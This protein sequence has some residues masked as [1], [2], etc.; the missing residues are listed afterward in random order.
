M[1][2]SS[3]TILC[4]NNTFPQRL[5]WKTGPLQ[6]VTFPNKHSYR[7]HANCQT[8]GMV[9]WR[10]LYV[11]PEILPVISTE[12]FIFYLSLQRWIFFLLN[13]HL[14]MDITSDRMKTLHRI[15]SIDNRTLF[16][17]D[18]SLAFIWIFGNGLFSNWLW[19]F[20]LLSLLEVHFPVRE[21]EQLTIFPFFSPSSNLHNML[22]LPLRWLK[23]LGALLLLLLLLKLCGK[24][25]GR[26]Q[27]DWKINCCKMCCQSTSLFSVKNS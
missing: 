23:C 5:I 26:K 20:C 19:F 27:S 21:Q 25:D 24:P 8:P 14:G 1:T 13:G 7:L 10:Y 4:Q 11:S 16:L 2:P 12:H 6:F 22:H 9:A 17:K 3:W 18:K 15:S